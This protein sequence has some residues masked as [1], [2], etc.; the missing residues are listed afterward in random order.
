MVKT[1]KFVSLVFLA[2]FFCLLL[3]KA[4]QLIPLIQEMIASAGDEDRILAYMDTHGASG[5]PVLLSLSALQ[6]ILPVIPA[7]AVGIL[8]GLCY[9]VVWG[10]MIFLAGCLAGNLFIFLSIRQLRGMVTPPVKHKVKHKS[11]L[12]I[13]QLDKIKRPEI[14]AF[15]CF[16]IPGL[17]NMTPYLFA[18]TNIH[19]GRYLLAALAGNFPFIMMYV[20]LG[21]R[22]SS[23]NFAAAIVVAVIAAVLVLIL[24]LFRKK[25]LDRLLYAA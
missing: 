11:L 17:G 1:E 22:V 25:I 3:V 4:V 7:P 24:F 23:G 16:L 10:P 15:F 6:A 18:Q 2:A 12:S 14:V 8:T 21:Y 19:L 20:F 9:G 13:E 5:V